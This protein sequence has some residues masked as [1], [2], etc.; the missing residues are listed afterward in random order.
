MN[1]Q[2][3]EAFSR[4]I[5]YIRK[6]SEDNIKGE[7]SKQLNSLEYQRQFVSEAQRRYK[8]TLVHPPFEDD[9]T[10]YEAFAR[11]GFQEMLDYLQDHKNEVDGIICTEISRLARNF[12]DGGMVLWYMQSNIIKRIYTPTK[13][14]TN[15]SSDQLMVAIEF[16][17]SKKSSDD[18][19]YRT[20]E[21]MRTKVQKM[22][23]PSRP[24]ILGYKTVGPVGAKEWVIDERKGPL[25]V[26]V[27]EQFA[28]GKYT[29]DQIAD[30]AYET[31]LRSS[32]KSTTTGKIS[33]NTWR[34]RLRDE[35]YISIFYQ[36]EERIAGEYKPLI[37]TSTFYRVQEIIRS[38][39][40]PKDTHIEYAYSGMVKCGFCGDLLSGTNKKGITYYR[41]SKRKPPCK[42]IDRITYVPE[43]KLEE[44]LVNEFN[45]IEIDE[46]T[47]EAARDYVVE[48]NQ[49]HRLNLKKD[50]RILNEKAN[51]EKELQID[52]GRKYAKSEISKSEYD[53]LMQDSY[54]K[55]AMY[56]NTIV[57]CGNI[58]HDLDELL[59]QF[60][61]DV[62]YVT[63]RL[64]NALPSNKREMVD[65]FCE[66]LEWRDEKARWNW[67]KPYFF[68]T[69]QSKSSTV[70]P[71]KDLFI[72]RKIE[73]GFSLQN[74]QT[75]FDTF[76]LPVYAS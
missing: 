35:H 66:N 15:S 45:R 74:I 39:E 65:I 52:I 10:G 57:K 63:S 38:N 51:A 5:A 28:T 17:M 70:L 59:Y 22:K 12:G 25:V 6:S 53:R 21:G 69:K 27:F 67:K 56:R 23:H 71:L 46:K 76:H 44:N 2:S 72:N 8:L 19:G 42:N 34:N 4:V 68:L 75:V 58:V 13:I 47:W 30:Y 24:A 3:Q 62:K 33:V 61:D 48:L 7:A 32:V 73:F 41:C 31:G 9:K 26:K 36:D 55:E 43:T 16:A 37:D 1:D 20:R 11:D 54:Q 60:L 14:F 64:K 29:F 49:P 50:I 18:T 40:H